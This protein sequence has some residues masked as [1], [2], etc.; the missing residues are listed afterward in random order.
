MRSA[1]VKVNGIPAGRLSEQIN[2]VEFI[3]LDHYL[4][5]P[6][7]PAVSLTLPK[8]SEPFRSRFLFPFFY[9]LLAEGALKTEQCLNLK[10]DEKD[11]FGRLLKTTEQETIGAVTVLEEKT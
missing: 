6:S 7:Q 8:Q 9:G 4:N 2:N 11:H 3:Y 1:I 10:L 5:D